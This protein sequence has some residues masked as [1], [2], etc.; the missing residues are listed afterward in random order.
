MKS[1]DGFVYSRTIYELSIT[2]LVYAKFSP[3]WLQSAFKLIQV[4]NP[5]FCRGS[6]WPTLKLLVL[7]NFIVDTWHI[8]V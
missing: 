7:S 3:V 5:I 1:A 4:L 8:F 2:K 6:Y